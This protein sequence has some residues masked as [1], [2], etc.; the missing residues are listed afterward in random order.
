VKKQNFSTLS[1]TLSAE[2]IS[3]FLKDRKSHMQDAI[4]KSG[5][6]PY[7]AQYIRNMARSLSDAPGGPL[8]LDSDDT[9]APVVDTSKM[10]ARFVITT[11]DRDRHGDIVIPRGC[12]NHLKN[13]TRNP[14]V[15]FAHNTNDLPIASAR[16]LDGNLALDILDD[17]IYSTAY[18][19]GETRE[20]EIIFRL[21]ARGELQASS[22]GFLPIRASILSLDEEEQDVVDLETGEEILNFRGSQT[23][24]TPSLRF[25]EWDMIE[26]SVVPIPA[27]QEALAAHL[28]RGHVEGEKLSPTI[29]RAL[30]AFVPARKSTTLSLPVASNHPEETV[31]ESLEDAIEKELEAEI[32]AEDS[33]KP[34]PEE[35]NE[36][37]KKYQQ[38]TNMSHSELKKW[39]ENPCSKRAS[40]DNG[41]LKRN[42]ELLSTP[43]S[44]WT[45]KHVKWANKT[46]SFNSRM[47]GMPRGKP[48]SQECPW[49]KRDISL[50]N[51]AWDPGQT[52]KPKKELEEEII[53]CP[54]AGPPPGLDTPVIER[55]NPPAPPKDQITGSDTNK[56]GSASDDKGK[57]TIS[58]ETETALK[59][60]VE[61]HNKKMQ[62]KAAWCKTTLGALKSVYR[63][64]AGAFS[65]SHRPG[66]TRAQWAFARVNAFL[67]LCEKGKPENEKYVSDNDLLHPDHPKYS[68]DKKSLSVSRGVIPFHAYALAPQDAKWDGPAAKKNA[69]VETLKKICAWYDADHADIKSAYKLP[70]HDAKTLKTVW[71][72]V[73]A[74][75]AA[76]LGSRGG[77]D[78]PEKDRIGVYNHL[79]RHYKEFDKPAPE[80]RKLY[81]LEELKAIFPDIDLKEL[82]TVSINEELELKNALDALQSPPSQGKPKKKNDDE[83]DEEEKKAREEEEAKAEEA[84]EEKAEDEEEAKS[85]DEAEEEKAM[86]DEE[87]SKEEDSDDDHHKI[88]KSMSEI[89]NS[90]HECSTAHTNLLKGINDKLDKC[91]KALEPKPEKEDKAKEEEDNMKSLLTALTTLKSNQDA[92]NRRLFEVTGRK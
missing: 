25:L 62:G 49:S 40:L 30:S 11:S 36:V 79:A 23:R 83:E 86:E 29:R 26:W 78:I 73:R 6:A 84:E 71:N 72:G 80:Y 59:N 61:E 47:R 28:S 82:T 58:K 69:D 64:G 21:I 53:H 66:K 22:I 60:K 51:W 87:E 1:D 46:I 42:L 45:K 43:K 70:H 31:I 35:L 41:P 65:T 16:D 68:K 24:S 91:M 17:R 63:R 39:A 55:K 44:S 19:H 14:R 89:L 74:A 88:L 33:G 90:M 52:P 92:L 4:S 38:E 9:E 18:F 7:P 15:F 54:P 13:Y 2:L 3:R 81:T 12:V 67:H 27:N 32:L 76:L 8:A 48:L 57:I 5:V 77:V 34:D 10:T 37:F 20:S 75:M 85:E 50:K 56:P